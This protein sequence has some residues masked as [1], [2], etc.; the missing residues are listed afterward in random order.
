M[1]KS[2]DAADF[3]NRNK[4]RKLTLKLG[5]TKLLYCSETRNW[6]IIF[7]AYHTLNFIFL[8]IYFT[9]IFFTIGLNVIKE[10]FKDFSDF[11]ETFFKKRKGELTYREM[12]LKER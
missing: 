12:E 9:I 6:R 11:I 4:F 5:M 2:E 7:R 10:E 8:P 1:I 3:V